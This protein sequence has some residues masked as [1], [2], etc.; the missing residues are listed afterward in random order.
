MPDYVLGMNCKLFAGAAGAALSSLT[1]LTNVKDVNVG[2]EAGEADVTT[3]ANSGWRATASTLK[4]STI[5]FEMV[6]KPGDTGFDMFQAAFLANTNVSMAALTGALATANSDGPYGD[7]SVTNF[8]RSEPLEEAATASVT[9]KLAVW[10]AW[11][12]DGVE[13]A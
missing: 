3:R 5:E 7:W 8:S 12:E 4:E 2:L 1:E 13:A 9:C 11:I 10:D 6:W